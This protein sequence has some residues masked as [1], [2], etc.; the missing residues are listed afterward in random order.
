[1]AALSPSEE[2]QLQ[3][4][5]EMFL[6]I[7]QSQPLDYQSL[8]ILKEA[9][10]KLGMQKDVMET[11]KRIAE[12][13][14]QLGQLSSAI[15]EYETILQRFPDDPDV[16]KALNEIENKTNS[17]AG[18]A[19]EP[20]SLPTPAAADTAKSGK[21]GLP[22]KVAEQDD[23]K[24]AMQRVFVD[25]KLVNA[26]DF[27]R[28]WLTPGPEPATQVSEPFLQIMADK[29]VLSLEKSLKL[30]IERARIGYMPLEK[31]DVDLELAKSFPRAVCLKWCVLPF[32]RMSKSVLVAT[33]NPF[34]K[35]AAAELQ[36]ATPN[37]IIW[38][39]TS[40]ADLVKAIKK[41]FR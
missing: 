19:A 21:S 23:G 17:F 18:R 32:D 35:Q 26:Q 22:L 13:Y 11:S 28:L 15:M 6:V 1:M 31:Y 24:A 36:A 25:G 38:Y 14:V 4:T 10:M 8:E 12:A 34:N 5:I 29:G 40:P 37:R 20:P 39:M 30:V 33:A 16:R 7:T 9:Y 3:Q 41:V 2:A 27:G